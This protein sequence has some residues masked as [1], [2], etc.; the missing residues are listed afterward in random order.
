MERGWQEEKCLQTPAEKPRGG[1]CH[2]PLLPVNHIIVTKNPSTDEFHFHLIQ[3]SS[4]NN[5]GQLCQTQT[6]VK[7]YAF[8]SFF[9]LSTFS[10]TNAN[11]SSSWKLSVKPDTANVVTTYKHRNISSRNGPVSACAVRDAAGLDSQALFKHV[12]RWSRGLESKVSVTLRRSKDTFEL[13]LQTWHFHWTRQ[14]QRWHTHL[15]GNEDNTDPH[16]TWSY[17]QSHWIHPVQLCGHTWSG[18]PGKHG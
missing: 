17:T 5:K 8:L 16:I 3:D 9:S 14:F 13:L 15:V 4:K 11:T 10:L 1:G 2:C 7:L 6:E 12:I 18:A